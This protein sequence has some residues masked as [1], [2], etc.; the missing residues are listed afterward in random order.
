MVS[1]RTN[2]FA[3]SPL[4]RLS[5]LR[6][7]HA[8]LNTIIAS[9]AARWLVFRS[10]QPLVIVKPGHL[11]NQTLAYLT[12][13]DVS[14]FLGS[15]PFFGQGGEQSGVVVESGENMHSPTEAARHHNSPVVFLGVHENAGSNALPSSA[16]TD[17]ETAIANLDGTPYFAMDVV[18]LD[19]PLEQLKQ[20]IDAT[21]LARNGETLEWS[22]SKRMTELDM[23]SGA[24]YA[25]ARSLV[26]W[27]YRN[28]V[29]G[30]LPFPSQSFSL[31]I[32]SVQV[33]V[34][35][36]TQ[37]GEAGKSL[38]QHC[39][40]GQITLI[41]SLVLLGACLKTFCRRGLSF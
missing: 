11:K 6:T 18:E 16:F 35:E 20:T 3:G 29:N 36:P 26:D 34:R 10:G 37:C 38:V 27:N 12:T 8:F 13:T 40:L 9:P 2:L 30:L 15:E 21:S 41:R 31:N 23:F 25:E 39:S 17:A 32:S 19:Y 5:W 22:E 7:S 1:S 24:V 28:K 4:N 14:P 33:A